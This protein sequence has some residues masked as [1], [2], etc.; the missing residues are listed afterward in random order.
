MSPKTYAQIVTEDR[1]LVILR[2]LAESANY[3]SN[4]SMVA[5]C[6][7]E[8]GHGEASRDLIRTD[9]EWLREQGLL[10]VEELASV[11]IATLTQRGFET[12]KG[13]VTVP[14]VRRPSPR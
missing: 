6:V 9:F 8:I 5:M 11:Q 10:T 3:E 12:A 14:G 7:R 2:T 4:E 1:R 13:I